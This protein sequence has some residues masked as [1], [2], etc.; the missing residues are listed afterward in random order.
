LRVLWPQSGRF[1]HRALSYALQIML[2]ELL[3]RDAVSMNTLHARY[4]AL[5]ELVGRLLGIVPNCDSYLEIWPPAFRTYNVMVPNL[6]NLPFMMWGLGAPRATVGLAMYVSSRTAGCAYCS[7][8]ACTFALRRGASVDAVASALEDTPALSKADRIAVRVARAMSHVPAA[9]DEELRA[10]LLRSFSARHAE[11]IILAVA[12]M[13][14]L[15]KTMD[16]LGVPLEE[17]TVADVSSIITP[18]GWRAGKH[19]NRP[20]TAGDP[21]RPDSLVARFSLIRYAPRAAAYDRKLT[22][23]IPDKW[24]IVGE[25]LQQ[26]TGHTFPVLSRI[27]SR[28]AVRAIAAMIRENFSETVVGRAEKL[29]AGLIYARTVLDD[30]LCA[31]LRSAGAREL[32]ES[33]LQSLARAISYSPAQVDATLLDSSRAITPAGII[34][35][36]S[37]IALLQMLYRLSSFWRSDLVA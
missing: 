24:P 34:E 7:A 13:G 3:R 15:N 37:F 19:L 8:H 1:G 25:Y 9:V 33:P 12:M 23:G 22:K 5:L 14:W 18:S 28:R 26:E 11:D 29:A 27:K 10:E 36:V 16:A 30:G 31:E 6:L 4:G 20:V 2:V 32:P 35:L 21:P 17:P